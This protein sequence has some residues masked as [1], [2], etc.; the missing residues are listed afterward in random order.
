MEALLIQ[1]N[2]DHPD[3]PPEFGLPMTSEMERMRFFL[4]SKVDDVI[5]EHVEKIISI[6]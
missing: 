5:K 1:H 6:E 4:K 3:I 2:Q